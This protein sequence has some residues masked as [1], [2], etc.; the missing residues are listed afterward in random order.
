[1]LN[2]EIESAESQRLQGTR[3]CNKNASHAAAMD[4]M[5][6]GYLVGGLRNWRKV[7]RS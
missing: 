3:F 4:F 2:P 1:V 6:G 7:F 5:F